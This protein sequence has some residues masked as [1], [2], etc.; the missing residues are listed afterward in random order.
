MRGLLDRSEGALI[1]Q[2]HVCGASS[3]GMSCIEVPILSGS[4]TTSSSNI[5]A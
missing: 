3:A 4:K 5:V 2:G 1:A